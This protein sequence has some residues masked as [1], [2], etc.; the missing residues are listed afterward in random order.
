LS[1]LVTLR[2]LALLK[3]GLFPYRPKLNVECGYWLPGRQAALNLNF[4]LA[5]IGESNGSG[6]A[7]QRDQSEAAT[8][9]VAEMQQSSPYSKHYILCRIAVKYFFSPCWHEGLLRSSSF[10]K[11]ESCANEASR[12]RVTSSRAPADDSLV[13]RNR[14]ASGDA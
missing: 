12:R 14:R 5:M 4:E 9:K 10:S 3:Q 6:S 11:T 2:W 13:D 1:V 7:A 8:D